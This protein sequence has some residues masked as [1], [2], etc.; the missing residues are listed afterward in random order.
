MPSLRH[1]LETHGSLLL[2]D[3]A[4]GRIQVGLMMQPDHARWAVST[5]EAGTGLFHCLES[6]AINPMEAA[7]VAFC[8]GP[9]SILGI[10]TSA[11]AIRAWQVLRSRPVYAYGSLAVVAHALGDPEAKII[12]DAR[13]DTWHC[14]QMNHPLQRGGTA[15][16]HGTL[17]Q[18]EGFR[19]WSTPPAGV[20]ITDYTL[21][22]LLPRVADAPL[23]VP[24]ED[25]DAFM[26]EAPSYRTWEPRI[27][28]AP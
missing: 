7:A 16:L 1:I 18:P 12:A 11:M 10:R 8:E 22:N 17:Y 28:R 26:H 19:H 21:G 27:H 20:R 24:T 15:E 14:Q 6:L 25:P 4:S 2:L 5:Q 23:F 3:A 13:R 9:G